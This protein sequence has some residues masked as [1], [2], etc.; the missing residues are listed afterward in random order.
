MQCA[1]IPSCSAR[2]LCTQCAYCVPDVHCARSVPTVHLQCSRTCIARAACMARS[3][4]AP[5]PDARSK[6]AR[7]GG[8]WELTS[9]EGYAAGEQAFISYGA[10]LDNLHLLLT[11]VHVASRCPP[12]RTL[13]SPHTLT[14]PRAPL[15]QHRLAS[16][17]RY[18]FALPNNPNAL[19]LFG[20]SELLAACASAR[21]SRHAKTPSPSYERRS[22]P[23]VPLGAGTLVSV[24]GGAALLRSGHAAWMP[25]RDR[26]TA[27]R[28]G[29]RCRL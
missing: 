27:G 2:A 18:G 11:C 25:I 7:R 5:Y 29:Q 12:H 19:L 10:E 14:H 9:R 17:C 24:L 20:P 3:R 13:A 23:L 21:H 26:G 16:R 22:S 4:P 28:L 6:L 8:V 1:R 15:R